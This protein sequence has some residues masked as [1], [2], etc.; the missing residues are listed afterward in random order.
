MNFGRLSVRQGRTLCALPH[1]WYP[2]QRGKSRAR[3]QGERRKVQRPAVRWVAQSGVARLSLLA[4][5]L[6]SSLANRPPTHSS[7]SGVTAPQTRRVPPQLR[8]YPK[9]NHPQSP[10]S[11]APASDL[12]ETGIAT[13]SRCL[14]SLSVV[15]CYF[16]LLSLLLLL[17]KDA[18]KEQ[19][20]FPSVPAIPSPV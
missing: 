8:P 2:K 18:R 17:R 13:A 1:H 10:K 12:L 15:C 16:A 6:F 20:G 3:K 11:T 9:L 14:L 5:F 19:P 7:P 4:D